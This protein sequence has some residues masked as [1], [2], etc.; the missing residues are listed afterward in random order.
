[1]NPLLSA[2]TQS[3]VINVVCMKASI[4]RVTRPLFLVHCP[5]NGAVQWPSREV[6]RANANSL[7]GGDFAGLTM[8]QA[9][10]PIGIPSERPN[11]TGLTRGTW[12]HREVT[13]G[14]RTDNR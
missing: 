6:I 1:M 12:L 2:M 4:I 10:E 11:A 5:E 9:A 3:I 7:L 14:E 8:A 13:R